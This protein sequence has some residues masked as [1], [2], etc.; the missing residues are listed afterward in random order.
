MTNDDVSSNDG[1]FVV[2]VDIFFTCLNCPSPPK[3]PLRQELCTLGFEMIRVVRRTLQKPDMQK[4]ISYDAYLLQ[5]GNDEKKDTDVSSLCPTEDDD[6]DC[7]VDEDDDSEDD[8]DFED[9]WIISKS[10]TTIS[11]KM[12]ESEQ[13]LRPWNHSEDDWADSDDDCAK[14]CA[15]DEHASVETIDC[16]Y[17]TTLAAD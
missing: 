6:S 7:Q 16:K 15:S 14:S 5:F 2:D 13:F 8:D 3:L 9:D 12:V 11:T 1:P 4:A 17:F 10:D